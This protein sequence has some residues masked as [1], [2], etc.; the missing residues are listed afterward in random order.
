MLDYY[1]AQNALREL[2]YFEV[3]KISKFLSWKQWQK[4]SL[5]GQ[6]ENRFGGCADTL[7]DLLYSFFR[8]LRNLGEYYGT[9]EP[10]CGWHMQP[11]YL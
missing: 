4:P 6:S 8:L 10:D 2:F 5:H 9:K 7:R 3:W 11:A 1:A